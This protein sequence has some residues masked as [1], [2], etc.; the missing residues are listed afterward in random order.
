MKRRAAFRPGR[1]RGLLLGLLLPGLVGCSAARLHLLTLEYRQIEPEGP[2]VHE[3]SAREGYFWIDETDQVRIGLR[4]NVASWLDPD[5]GRTL[6]VSLVLDGIPADRARNYPATRRTLRG[7]ASDKNEHVR[8]ASIRGITA[9][10]RDGPDRIRGRF[11]I[12]TRYQKF[13]I[14]L[15]WYGTQQLLVLGEFVAVRDREKTEAIIARTEA[16]GM[17]R[18]LTEPQPTRP[19]PISGPAPGP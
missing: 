12:S 7:R 5:A 3:K 16:D 9:V 1:P 14:L 6:E 11:R 13:S 19:V 8:F 15:G 4:D 2:L 10:W 18:S 17:Q